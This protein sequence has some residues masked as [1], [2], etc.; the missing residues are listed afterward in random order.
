[1]QTDLTDS[2]VI[3]VVQKAWTQILNFF[4]LHSECI[5]D[6]SSIQFYSNSTGVVNPVYFVDCNAKMSNGELIPLFLVLKLSG[7][8]IKQFK[9]R[10]E[11]VVMQALHMHSVIPVPY[12]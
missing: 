11:A 7:T 5:L 4:S 9:T 6:T 3:L 8:R 12:I 2:E 1:M 10:N